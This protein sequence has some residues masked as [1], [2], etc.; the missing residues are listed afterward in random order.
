M[1]KRNYTYSEWLI[2]K[3][4]YHSKCKYNPK[5]HWEWKKLAPLSEIHRT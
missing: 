3:I 2:P 5:F 4:L 1:G